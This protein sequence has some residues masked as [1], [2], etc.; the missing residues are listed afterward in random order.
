MNDKGLTGHG[1]VSGDTERG[2]FQRLRGRYAGYTRARLA[3][4]ARRLRRAIYPEREAVQRIELAGPVDRIT[5]KV[6]QALVFRDVQIGA[7]LGPLWATYWA[8]V[9]ARIPE[10][11]RGA[12][13]DL[14]WDSRSEALLWLDGRSSQGLN[15]GRNFARLTQ[16]AKAGE[17]I[18]FHIEIAC[19]RA[20]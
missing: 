10:N 12:R 11:W 17:T 19:N 18:T 20:F 3:Q 6:A 15:S 4:F 2:E 1:A 5:F 7:P 8:R 16:A 14:H 13:V 9:T